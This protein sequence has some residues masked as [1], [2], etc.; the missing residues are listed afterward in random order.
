MTTPKTHLRVTKTLKERLNRLS[1]TAGYSS[2][3]LA[4]LLL[5]DCLD[6]IDDDLTPTETVTHVAIIRRRLGKRMEPMHALA[7]LDR[8]LV[9]QGKPPLTDAFITPAAPTLR[10]AENAP[11]KHR[12]KQSS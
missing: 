3:L 8:Y 5:T 7:L 11:A 12:G 4:D 9:S 2:E 6:Q 10:V 1:A